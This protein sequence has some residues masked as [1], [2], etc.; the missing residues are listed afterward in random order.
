V[1]R[2]RPGACNAVWWTCSHRIFAARHRLR[3]GN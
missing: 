2:S 3:P 1:I